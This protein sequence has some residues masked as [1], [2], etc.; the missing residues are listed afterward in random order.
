MQVIE[1]NVER[2]GGA[3]RDNIGRG[4]ADVDSGKLQVRRLE[5]LGAVVKRLALDR[6]QH[7]HQPG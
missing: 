1:P 4:V 7:T 2:S 3:T 6:R 5:M